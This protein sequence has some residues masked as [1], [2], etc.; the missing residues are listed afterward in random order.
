MHTP[1]KA[2]SPVSTGL[3]LP[4][5][6]PEATDP[7]LGN[8]QQYPQLVRISWPD[9]VLSKALIDLL[10]HFSWDQMSI[11]VSNDDYGTHGFKEFQDLA[12]QK[13]WRIHTIQSFDPTET[14]A[15]IEV[16]EQLKAI[17]DTG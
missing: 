4:Q 6:A 1:V 5:I 9:S 14:A 3:S 12:G 2:A 10:E 17:K 8:A 11:F 13:G 15:D 7:T 16:H